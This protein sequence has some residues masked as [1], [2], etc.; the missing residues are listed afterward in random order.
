MP[1]TPP[2]EPCEVCGEATTLRCAACQKAGI[3]LFFCSTRLGGAQDQLN[4]ASRRLDE[5]AIPTK[6]QTQTLRHQLEN[7]GEKP[8]E[9]V[10]KYLPGDAYDV[11][12]LTHKPLLV[13]FVRC[14]VGEYISHLGLTSEWGV[15]FVKLKRSNPNHFDADVARSSSAMI[16]WCIC[17]WIFYHRTMPRSYASDTWFSLLQ[18]KLLIL[19]H[20]GQLMSHPDM[21]T[22]VAQYYRTTK[23][24]FL[25][26][27]KSGMG[28]GNPLF[29]TALRQ[30]KLIIL[31]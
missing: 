5:P 25:V 20:L 28:T 27:V 19:H 8:C 10:L 7:W 21:D 4:I 1:I 30:F 18:H 26:W 16:T 29:V 24:R 2:A 15:L 9:D 3:D 12:K 23:A 22:L 11:S 6:V 13:T 17:D 31:Q 14:V